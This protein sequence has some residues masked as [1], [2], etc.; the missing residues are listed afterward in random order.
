M[1]VNKNNK[2]GVLLINLGSPDGTDYWS[3]R[4]YLKEFL[5]DRRV[6]EIP[7]PIWWLILNGIILN[8]R[9]QKSGAKYEDVWDRKNDCAPLISITRNTSEK[10]AKHMQGNDRLV[11]DWA[12]RYGN[13]TI[14]SRI[15]GLMDQGCERILLFPLYPQY[16][17]ST[18]ATVMD[19]V[20]DALKKMRHQPSL[21]TVPPYYAEPAYINALATS[22][23]RQLGELEFTPD[24]IIASFHGL[25]QLFADRGDPYP[26]HCE[27]TFRRLKAALG[28]DGYKLQMTYQSRFGP[29]NWLQPYTD[30]T[31]E[32]IAGDGVKSVVVITPGFAADCL[33]TLEEISIENAEI[34]KQAGGENFQAISCLNDSDDALGMLDTLIKRELQG[35]S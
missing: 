16:S 21:R 2:I 9:P 27:Q 8:T 35:W 32:K 10:L 7:R 4:R 26:K 13:P 33:E 30:K 12:M 6:V 34:F 5:G 24:V 18:T 17:A 23:K 25:P 1:T 14:K 22:L 29:A 15:D 28:D 11:I 31:L 20:A 3:V 19:N